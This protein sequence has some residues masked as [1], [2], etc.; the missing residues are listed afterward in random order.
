MGKQS[1][2]R[3]LFDAEYH[4]RHLVGEGSFHWQ[5]S[6]VR[7][8]LFLDEKF[9]ALYCLD[10]GRPSMPPSLLA[11]AFLLQRMTRSAMPKHTAERAWTWVGRCSWGWRSTPSP[12]PS[13]RCSNSGLILHDRVQAVFLHSMPGVDPVV[14]AVL[15]AELPELG[16]LGSRRLTALVARLNRDSGQYRGP[17]RV[18]GGRAVRTM[19][20]M[21]TVTATRHNPAIHDFY[22]RLCRRGKP[23]KVALVAA[24]RKLLLILNA[25]VRDYRATKL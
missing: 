14:A 9:A 25:V 15:V 4:F 3:S 17:R 10:N 16:Q 23:R 1:S 13:A 12:L 18:W 5:L 21:A 11:T 6:Q 8:Q 19:L 24:M 20:Y 22:T 7:D 2:Q